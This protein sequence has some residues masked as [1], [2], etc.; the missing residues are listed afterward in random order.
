MK[1]KYIKPSMVV[2]EIASGAQLLV[3]SLKFFRESTPIDDPNDV[4]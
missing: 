1:Q 2:Y 4:G 3:D